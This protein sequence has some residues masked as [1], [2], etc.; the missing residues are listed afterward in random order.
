MSTHQSEIIFAAPNRQSHIIHPMN[1]PQLIQDLIDTGWTYQRLSER[2]GA[3]VATLHD[4]KS[5]K[6]AEAKYNLGTK[7]VALHKRAMRTAAD[8]LRSE[9]K[10]GKK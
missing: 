7:L 4:L 9:R 5:G 1:W 2:T 10:K 3:G 8:K 6:S